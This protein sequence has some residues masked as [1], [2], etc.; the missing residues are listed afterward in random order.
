MSQFG[1]GT[2]G[3]ANRR[4]TIPKRRFYRSDERSGIKQPAHFYF[5]EV[6]VGHELVWWPTYFT[7]LHNLTSPC[8]KSSSPLTS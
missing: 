6:R 5:C 3:Q 1:M 4:I 2:R 8:R 7:E